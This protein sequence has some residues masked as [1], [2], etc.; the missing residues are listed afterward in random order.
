MIDPSR[1]ILPNTRCEYTP[2]D[3]RTG[4]VQSWHF[5]I[6]RELTKNLV[7]DL[8][9]VGNRGNSLVILGDYNQA[10]PNK[11]DQKEGFL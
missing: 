4:Y 8:A 5:T 1:V 9:Y 6:Q 2:P 11:Q 7:L 10:R 3:S